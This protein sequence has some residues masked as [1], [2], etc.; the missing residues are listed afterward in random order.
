MP[1]LN[2]DQHQERPQ[3]G[4]FFF[5]FF[6]LIGKQSKSIKSPQHGF[7]CL[8]RSQVLH[9]EDASKISPEGMTTCALFL[10]SQISL[11]IFL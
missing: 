6:P 2:L 3:H 9:C 8:S 11:M 5:F 7:T 10:V 1:T 4:W